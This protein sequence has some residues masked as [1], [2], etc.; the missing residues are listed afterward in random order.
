[1]GLY[2]VSMSPTGP[3]GATL[4]SAPVLVP[5]PDPAP[6]PGLP[7]GLSGHLVPAS[8]GALAVPDALVA[9][10]ASELLCRLR[11]AVHTRVGTVP[12]PSSSA[13]RSRPPAV[14]APARVAVLFSG[15]VD[16]MILAALCDGCLPPSEPV[17]LINVSFDD[18]GESPDRVTATAGLQ[19]LQA[20]Y[21]GR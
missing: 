4:V 10:A 13:P 19:E 12:A 17:D 18:T 5:W 9:D 3:G 6:C 8:A 1:M 16:C 20:A 15:G 2:R 7:P 21:P 11:H 14:D